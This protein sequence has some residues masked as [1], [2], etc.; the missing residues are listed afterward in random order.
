M[1]KVKL[2]HPKRIKKQKEIY[3]VDVRDGDK[4]RELVALITAK[5]MHG[6]KFFEGGYHREKKKYESK[7]QSSL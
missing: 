3:C 7:K 6:S 5:P 2:K 4:A 1:K